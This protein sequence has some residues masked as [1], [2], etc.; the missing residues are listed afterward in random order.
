MS[1]PIRMSI[2]WSQK[3][4]PREAFSIS[5][6]PS[7]C[8]PER[9]EVVRRPANQED[10]GPCC[11]G[12][13]LPHITIR[14]TFIAGFPGETEADFE[15]LLDWLWEVRLDRVGCFAFEPVDG[16]VANDL[17]GALPKHVREERQ[18]RLLAVQAEIGGKVEERIGTRQRILVDAVEEDTAV[19]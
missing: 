5:I 13:A 16:A 2:R 8:E 6:F 3:W 9:L 10:G 17:P 12:N 7:A 11:S 14:S 1:T 4:G 18:A 19:T 15:Y